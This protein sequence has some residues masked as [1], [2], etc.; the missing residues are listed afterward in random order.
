MFRKALSCFLPLIGEWHFGTNLL[1]NTYTLFYGVDKSFQ[2]FVRD[3]KDY[4][5]PTTTYQTGLK[6][7]R[8]VKGE[9]EGLLHV[10][11]FV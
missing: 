1:V 4:S 2:R 7:F 9:V 8:V 6:L 10:V 11:F 3:E 5:D